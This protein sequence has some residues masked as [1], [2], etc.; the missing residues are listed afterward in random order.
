MFPDRNRPPGPGFQQPNGRR[1]QPPGPFW[2]PQQ[3]PNN[4]SQ[5]MRMGQGRSQG[6]QG[7][8]AFRGPNNQQQRNDQLPPKKEGLLSRILG[9]SK[10]NAAP[11]NLFAP[12][13]STTNN[14]SSRSSGGGILDNLTKPDSIN[15]ML[16]NTQ[17]VLQAAEQFTPMVQQYGPVI[18]NLPSMWKVFRSISSENTETPAEE[19]KPVTTATVA[20]EPTLKNDMRESDIVVEPATEVRPQKKRSRTSGPKLYI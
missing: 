16:N 18:K 13:G 11:P 20:Q 2:G 14:S 1:M 3:P 6:F 4:F 19:N 12:A 15:N 5:P 17:K 7:P 8:Q 9:K 10:Q